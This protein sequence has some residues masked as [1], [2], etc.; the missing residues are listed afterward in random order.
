MYERKRVDEFIDNKYYNHLSTDDNLVDLL[1]QV[2]NVH[3]M[4]SLSGFEAL[5]KGKKVFCYGAPFY[6]GWGLTEDFLKL[7]EEIKY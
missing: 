3:T 7:I 2:D 4:S 6:A 1:N 5:L